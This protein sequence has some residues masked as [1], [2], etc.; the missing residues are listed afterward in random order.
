VKF[1]IDCQHFSGPAG[2]G[3]W[4]WEKA[5]VR[6]GLVNLITG[7]QT[8]SCFTER[9]PDVNTEIVNLITGKLNSNY[10]DKNNCCGREGKYFTQKE[11]L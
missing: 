10:S 2:D 3:H 1:C 11:V 6:P 9:Y 7:E 8:V 5:C 4:L